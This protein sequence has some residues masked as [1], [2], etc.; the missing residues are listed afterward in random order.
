MPKYNENGTIDIELDH[1]DYGLIPYTASKDAT[2]K[3]GIA[4]WKDIM[5]GKYGNISSYVKPDPM[6]H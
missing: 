4:V 2:D 1:P 6:K 5:N 3:T